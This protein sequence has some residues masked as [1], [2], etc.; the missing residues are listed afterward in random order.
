MYGKEPSRLFAAFAISFAVHFLYIV[1]TFVSLV[2]MRIDAGFV[3]AAVVYPVLSII[4]LIPLSISG[5]GVR[6]AT[7]A[8][9]FTLYG[10]APATG[11]ALSWLA[12]VVTMPNILVGGGIQLW[13][14]YRTR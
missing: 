5:I 12:F 2:A 13:E 6:D 14:M 11:V 4:L 3:F 7:L 10:L 1:A 9:L 8:V